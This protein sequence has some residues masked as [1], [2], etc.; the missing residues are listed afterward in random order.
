MRKLFAVCLILMLAGIVPAFAQKGEGP[1]VLMSY[2]FDGVTV[3]DPPD[4]EGVPDSMIQLDITG[5][6]SWDVLDD[7]DNV[8]FAE[9]LGAGAIMT[10]IGW[11]VTITTVGASWLSEARSY[12]DGS[13]QDGMG[14][15]L[16]P[17]VG[18]NMSG[19]ATYSS[20]GIIDLTD[21]AIPNIPVLADETLYVQF[22]ESFDDVANSVDAN[23][24]PTS[25][26]DIVGIGFVTP[27]SFPIPTL[28]TVGLIAL[29]TALAGVGVFLLRR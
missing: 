26:F 28:S 22:Y 18:D 12:F 8:V 1:S 3:A 29:L 27:G 6:E 10:G 7:P 19:S 16:T 20:G 15:F 2:T 21:N 9:V 14:L 13:D 11:D 5:V 4:V 25:T 17:G 24:D 23:Y